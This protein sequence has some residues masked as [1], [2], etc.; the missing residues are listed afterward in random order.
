LILGT[1]SKFDATRCQILRLKCTKFDDFRWGSTTDLAVG[2]YSAPPDLLAVFKGPILREKG[3]EVG[4][5][6]GEGKGRGRV[7]E[8]KREGGG[9]KGE[10]PGTPKYFGLELP[11]HGEHTTEDTTACHKRHRPT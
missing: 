10:G 6:K 3:E 2:A 8:R 11:P 7:E 1:I 9:R 5:G 4:E